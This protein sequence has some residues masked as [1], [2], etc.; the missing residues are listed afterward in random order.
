MTI[1]SLLNPASVAIIGASENSD[2]IGGRPLRYLQEFGFQGEIYPINP[3]RQ[4]VQGLVC[5]PSLDAL[6]AVPETV[7]IAVAGESAIAAVE[8]CAA[9]GVAAA[10]IMASGFGELGEDGKRTEAYMR[11]V[12][13]QANMRLV[14]PNSQGLANFGNGAVLN[15]STMFIESPPADGPVACISQSGAMSVVPYGLLRARGIGVRHVHATGN[16]CDVSVGE[17]AAEVVQDPEVRLLLLYLETLADPEALARA[18][19]VAR[20]RDVPII[21]LKSGRSEDGRRAAS[22]HTGAIA[23]SDRVVDAFFARNGIW[24]ARGTQELVRATELYLQGWHPEG[25]NLAVI[26]NSGATCVL[27][28]DAAEH[29]GLPLATFPKAIEA[30]LQATLPSFASPRNPVDITAALLTDSTLFS[31]VL[32]TAGKDPN[33][34]LFLIGIPV[35]GKGYDFPRFA[36]DTSAFI[37][38]RGKPVALA[39]PQ[40]KVRE[41]FSAQG[42]PV[43]ETEDQAIDAL[44]QFVDHQR[45]IQ[46][47][48][49]TLPITLRPTSV[50]CSA[51]LDESAALDYIEQTGVPVAR[52]KLCHNAEEA[53]DFLAASS[54]SIVLKACSRH[55]PHK[56]DHGLVKLGIADADT[57]NV[58]FAELVT[59]IEQ[60]GHRFDGILACEQIKG[61]RELMIGGHIDPTF[62][63]V[64]VIGDGGILVEAMPDNAVL[65]PPIDEGSVRDALR[66]L[67][68]APLFEGVRGQQALDSAAVTKVAQA[69][70]EL[71]AS[72]VTDIQSVD[73]NPL[74][75]DATG[76]WAVDALIEVAS[77]NETQDAKRPTITTK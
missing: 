40:S 45:L 24:R 75:V 27:A 33:V 52:H 44:A 64:V 6:P 14:G 74:I 68:I 54:G 28:A 46:R 53:I 51:T 67:R 35:S 26:S 31:K 63:A 4:T 17:L 18:A 62:G 43:F 66:S 73:I 1:A 65:L 3:S 71:L 38:D 47:A 22:S 8:A 5:F 23:N 56:S 58:A 32:P 36:S 61:E 60:L 69:V 21:A 41:A 7:I 2:K 39:A 48:R 9:A 16:D 34:D 59:G 57:L 29:A 11:T 25:R 10:I 77:T 55:I 37:R 12:A 42:V 70:A 76:A 50:G 72:S 20:E 49:R 19:Q 13:H 30:E 15:F